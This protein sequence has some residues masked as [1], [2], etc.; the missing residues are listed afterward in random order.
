ML[1]HSLKSFSACG[2]IL[3]YTYAHLRKKISFVSKQTHPFETWQFQV[4]NYL[5]IVNSLPYTCIHTPISNYVNN[6]VKPEHILLDVK[7]R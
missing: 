5:T 3:F 7:K 4:S 1:S 6:P 2:E